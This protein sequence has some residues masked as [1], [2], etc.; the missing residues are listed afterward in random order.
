M[1]TQPRSRLPTP[2][3]G[4]AFWAT[5]AHGFHSAA[6]AASFHPW[7]QAYAPPGL[8]GKEEPC[9]QAYAP[10]GLG[11]LGDRCPRV[12][13]RRWRGVVPPVATGL[14]PSG[15]RRK[16][17]TVSTGLRPFG[18]WL[19]GR[20]MSTGSTPPLARRRSTRGYRPTPLR[21]FGHAFGWVA[22][23]RWAWL[24]QCLWRGNGGVVP[25]RGVA[26]GG[27]RLRFVLCWSCGASGGFCGLWIT[28]LMLGRR[29]ADRQVSGVCAA[30]QGPGRARPIRPLRGACRGCVGPGSR[31]CR[32]GSGPAALEGAPCDPVGRP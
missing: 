4:L 3:R 5:D 8:G 17:G 28:G 16:G 12:P 20:P 7:L 10:S 27:I 15:A 18:A 14:R 22:R 23:A 9:L 29:R 21:G 11:F 32:G 25:C 31:P 19:S 30:A 24:E 2:L 26:R 1:G 13:L 6:G